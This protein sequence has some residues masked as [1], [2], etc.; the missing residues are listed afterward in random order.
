VKHQVPVHIR[1][2]VVPVE[3]DL[4]S[5]NALDPL[6]DEVDY[7]GKGSKEWEERDD[8]YFLPI[9]RWRGLMSTD[10]NWAKKSSHGEA[11]YEWGPVNMIGSLRLSKV[12]IV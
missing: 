5:W 3:E 2:N 7:I 12:F 4:R 9:G 11:S 1:V 8:T 10:L 6:G